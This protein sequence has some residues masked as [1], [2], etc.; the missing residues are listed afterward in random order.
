MKQ[1]CNSDYWQ[2]MESMKPAGAPCGADFDDYYQSTICPH[3]SLPPQLSESQLKQ[4]YN[5]VFGETSK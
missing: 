5:E 3:D 4:L 2:Y 1:K